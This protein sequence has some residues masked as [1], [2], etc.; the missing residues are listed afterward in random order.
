MA[1]G[2]AR[3]RSLIPG[4]VLRAY[5]FGLAGFAALYYGFPS[6]RLTV[7]GVT[8][9]DGKTTVVHLLHEMLASAGH[10][11]GSVSS[12]R[13]KIRDREEENLLKMTMPGRMRLQRFLAECRRIGCRFAIIEVTSQGVIQ[14]RHRFIRFAAGVLTNITP[15][16][17]EAHGSFERYR[18]AKIELFC[19]LPASG[20]AVLNRDDPSSKLF[21]QNTR[22][23][24]GW[25]SRSEIEL[26]RVSRP[27]RQLRVGPR[28]IQLDIEGHILEVS[29]GGVF[30][31]A[32]VIA[33]AATA[34]AFNV[35]LSAI[36]SALSAFRGVP[37]RMEYIQDR[38]FAVVVDYAVTPKALEQVYGALGKDLV[39]VFGSAGGGRDRQK[40]PKLGEIAG[41]FCRAIILTSDDPDDEDPAD[42]AKEIQSG[43]A[44]DAKSRSAVIPDRRQAIAQG[45]RSARPGDTVI[46]TGM[47]AQPWLVVDGKKI[48]WDDRRIV[49]EELVTLTH[50]TASV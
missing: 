5:H 24:V 23:Q 3:F 40:R 44:S 46:V 34:L 1:S 2:R 38:P 50:G 22:A 9:T 39:C 12:L 36:A 32:N 14:S 49:R 25:Y 45:L 15:E 28:N 37:G 42:I 16:H 17:I 29:L 6:R 31:A 43:M 11:V 27:V 4:A 19:A 26:G 10:G 35:S 8:G 7:I 41:R 48:P 33:A 13:F 20:T 21:S 47:G 30:N 18:A